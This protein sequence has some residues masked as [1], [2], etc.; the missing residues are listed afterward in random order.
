MTTLHA[1]LHPHLSPDGHWLAYDSSE[2]G[3]P[4]VEVEKYPE[5]APK[6]SVSQHGGFQPQWRVDGAEL[7][8][9]TN[10]SDMMAAA[11]HVSAGGDRIEAD[12]PV[13]LF[14]EDF[15]PDGENFVR[16]DYA[17]ARDGRFLL[18]VSGPAKPMTVVRNW[19]QGLK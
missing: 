19:F 17:V 2:T 3:T 11:I 6:I 5:G 1:G 9:L 7:F 16:S 13:R 18:R 8:F 12:D 14:R 4:Q 10:T 15:Q